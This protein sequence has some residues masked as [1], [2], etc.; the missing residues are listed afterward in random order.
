ML[1]IHP[2]LSR[3]AYDAMATTAQY[4]PAAVGLLRALEMGQE[5]IDHV[6]GT[7]SICKPSMRRWM[8]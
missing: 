1:K 7:S 3:E 5:T 4:V 2:G 6:M 8:K